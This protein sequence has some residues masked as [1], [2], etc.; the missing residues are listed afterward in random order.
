M[1]GAQHDGCASTIVIVFLRKSERSAGA[2]FQGRGEFW[3]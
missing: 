1:H 2:P 3:R